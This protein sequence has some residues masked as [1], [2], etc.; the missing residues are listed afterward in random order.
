MAQASNQGHRRAKRGKVLLDSS[1]FFSLQTI[2]QLVSL[3][4]LGRIGT[5]GQQL[6]RSLGSCTEHGRVV[7][8]APN[9]GTE[10]QTMKQRDD[11]KN[12][13]RSRVS[14]SKPTQSLSVTTMTAFMAAWMAFLLSAFAGVHAIN[15]VG[16]E[17]ALLI[18]ACH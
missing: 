18:S 12:N 7:H 8:A 11:P 13:G 10:G 3:L 14:P 1:G 17:C 4:L 16:H 5:V 9:A 15:N 6:H 2:E